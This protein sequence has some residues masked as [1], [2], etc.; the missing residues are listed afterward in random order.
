MNR[1]CVLLLG[2]SVSARAMAA[3][4]TPDGP[5]PCYMYKYEK[6]AEYFAISYHNPVACDDETTKAAQDW[7]NAGSKFGL[8]QSAGYPTT[9]I[10]STVVDPYFQVSF[11]GQYYMQNGINHTAE[12][13]YKETYGYTVINGESLWLVRDGDVR[14]NNDY[15]ANNR[16]LCDNKE[17]MDPNLNQV[18]FGK[19]I[20]EELGH[21]HGQGH[22]TTAG[23]A[24]TNPT[25]AGTMYYGLCPAEAQAI[26]TLYST[27][28]LSPIYGR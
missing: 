17:A 4:P 3:C 8:T 18:D 16:I 26:R 20:A 24:M 23:C 21:S 7:T 5:N 27:D 14:V 22:V 10:Q 15:Y 12:S 2:L 28:P 11:E 6:N 13:L 1:V 25:V 9:Y 19:I